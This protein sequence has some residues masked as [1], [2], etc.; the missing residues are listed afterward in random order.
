MC[1][2]HQI[3]ML[4]FVAITLNLFFFF[5]G[6]RYMFHVRFTGTLWPPSNEVL[7]NEFSSW[8]KPSRVLII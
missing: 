2:R 8:I 3:I 4:Y 5:F 1:R 6:I 7:Q